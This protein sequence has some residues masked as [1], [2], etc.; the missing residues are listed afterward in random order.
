MN[1]ANL[2]KL[3]G[4]GAGTV[5]GLAL[6][7]S[8]ALAQDRDSAPSASQPNAAV[9]TP[10]PEKAKGPDHGE[11]NTSIA[12]L[13]KFDDFD[14]NKDGAIAKEEIPA[15]DELALRFANYDSNGDGKLS[16]EEFAKYNGG[17]EQLAHNKSK[18]KSKA[19][20]KNQ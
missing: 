8:A 20:I 2:I 6:S 1:A 7:A 5:I 14:K 10:A 17:K 16:Q 13:T 15:N 19:K 3:A 18:D 11:L 12:K 4:L 9:T